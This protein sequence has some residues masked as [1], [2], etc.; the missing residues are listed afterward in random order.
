[1][2]PNLS[3]TLSTPGF[4]DMNLTATV[5]EQSMTGSLNGSGFINSGITL[6]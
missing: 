4:S 1:V 6:H 5:G 3:L 2:P